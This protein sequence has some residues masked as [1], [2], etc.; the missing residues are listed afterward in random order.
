MQK[1]KLRA[2]AMLPCASSS[3]TPLKQQT[4]DH[5]GTYSRSKKNQFDRTQSRS[6]SMLP[7]AKGL[8]AEPTCDKNKSHISVLQRPQVKQTGQKQ[9]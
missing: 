5:S 7:R 2:T 8:S 9:K 3:S 4:L 1:Q 6:N